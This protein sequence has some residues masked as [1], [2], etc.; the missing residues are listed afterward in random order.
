L[1][2]KQLDGGERVLLRL[3]HDG[4]EAV[5]EGGLDCALEARWDAHELA[6]H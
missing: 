5:G 1:T 3:D 4:V 6:D 2:S